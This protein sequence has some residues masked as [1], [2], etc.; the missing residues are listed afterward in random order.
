MTNVTDDDLLRQITAAEATIAVAKRNADQ[1]KA[2]LLA[3]RKDEITALL[4]AKDEPFGKVEITVGNHRVAVTIPKKV[5]Y[6]QD[7][8]KAKVK[9]L[10]DS[11]ENPDMYIHTEYGVSETMFK[12]FPI[13]VQEW[14]AEARTV[15]QGTVSLKVVEVKE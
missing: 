10:V 9:Q 4:Q 2:E 6:N 1:A 7:L 3:R 11:G 13:E 12:N 15:K 5:E 14:L 8:L